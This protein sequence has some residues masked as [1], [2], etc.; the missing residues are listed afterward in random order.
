MAWGAPPLRG[1]AGGQCLQAVRA[2]VLGV[3][4]GRGPREG[5]RAAGGL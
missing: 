2:P 1:E 4:A 5:H 3:W